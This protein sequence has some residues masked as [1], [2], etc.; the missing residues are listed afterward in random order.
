[1]TNRVPNKRPDCKVILEAKQSWALNEDE[2]RIESELNSLFELGFKGTGFLIHSILESKFVAVKAKKLTRREFSA[3]ETTNNYQHNPN[4]IQKFLAKLKNY[5]ITNFELRTK[6]IDCLVSLIRKYSN[7]AKI[8]NLLELNAI[9]CLYSLIE[10]NSKFQSAQKISEL[11]DDKNDTINPDQLEKV[12]EV[13]LTAM[14]LYP[15]H[16][17][18]QKSSLIILY[19]EQILENLTTEK[20]KCTKIVMDSLVNFKERDMNLMASV[21]SSIHLIKLSIHEREILCTSDVYVKTLLNIINCNTCYDLTEN[22]LSAL[23]NLLVDSSKNC[24]IF[25]ELKG[26]DF[27]FSLLEVRPNQ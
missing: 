6:L 21:I 13:T 24:S 22:S 9:Y 16:Q 15:N 5:K 10:N 8:L 1:M 25:L 2:F 12:V 18:L 23:V 27:S 26:L 19:S 4:L 14:E 17:Q 3:L 20:Y 7:L 11:E